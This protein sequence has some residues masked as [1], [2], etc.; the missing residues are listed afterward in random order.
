ME[1]LNGPFLQLFNTN[2]VLRLESRIQIN[3]Y[4]MI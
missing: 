1:K 3:L 2:P 4:M